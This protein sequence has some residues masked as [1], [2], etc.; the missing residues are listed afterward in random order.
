MGRNLLSA[1]RKSHGH[2]DKT[3]SDHFSQHDRLTGNACDM[4]R[5]CTAPRS[6]PLRHTSGCGT[7]SPAGVGNCARYADTTS[8][9]TL[10]LVA[11]LFMRRL[12]LGINGMDDRQ[13]AVLV[14]D[15]STRAEAHRNLCV[16]IKAVEPP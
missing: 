10:S 5:A 16:A 15:R 6:A 14:H 12:W 9:F 3:C 13:T 11:C 1:G 4:T 2:D 7:S 8:S